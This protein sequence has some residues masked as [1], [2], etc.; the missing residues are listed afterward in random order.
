MPTWN[1]WLLDMPRS[2]VAQRACACHMS[3][4]QKHVT[5]KHVSVSAVAADT[6]RGAKIMG[7]KEKKHEQHIGELAQVCSEKKTEKSDHCTQV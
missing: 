5:Q 7:N 3:A 2:S 1:R 6:P 4:T